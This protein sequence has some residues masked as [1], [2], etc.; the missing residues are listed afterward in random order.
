MQ[1][2]E[3]KIRDIIKQEILKISGLRETD[4]VAPNKSSWDNKKAEFKMLVSNLLNNLETDDYNDAAGEISKTINILR[5][6]KTKID[7]SLQDNSVKEDINENNG[8]LKRDDIVKH[9][10]R[11]DEFGDKYLKYFI[12]SSVEFHKS[13]EGYSL[14]FNLAVPV[15]SGDD[16]SEDIENEIGHSYG[17]EKP[18][19][20][21][22]KV[23]VNYGGTNPV[24]NVECLIYSIS[25]K[26]GY[27]I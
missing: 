8:E 20:R 3:K 5:A 9:I 15:N 25:V 22:T 10:L 12:P 24:N 2:Q 13:D 27:D 18:G 21:Y 23:L 1:I 16:I 17:G 11:V 14:W 7:K 6:W 26:S 19:G 4:L